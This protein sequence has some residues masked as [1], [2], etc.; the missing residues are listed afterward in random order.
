MT[1]REKE[2]KIRYKLD[3]VTPINQYEMKAYNIPFA[4]NTSSCREVYIKGERVLEFNVAGDMTFEQFSTKPIFRDELV[5]YLFSL[6][7]QLVSMVQN[8]LKLDKIVLDLRFLYVRLC[9][10]SLQ[11]LY[12]PLDKEFPDQNVRT[13]LQELLEKMMPA[14][15][16]SI[17]C[18]NQIMDYFNEHAEFDVFEFNRFIKA[19][20]EKSQLL[21]IKDE[22]QETELLERAL[23]G[24]SSYDIYQDDALKT[25]KLSG[26]MSDAKFTP[27]NILSGFMGSN[28]SRPKNYQNLPQLKRK[29]TGEVIYID[30]QVF[31]IGKAEQG[32][33]YRIMGN[34]SISRR[35]VYITT[36]KGKSYLRDNNSTN[37]TYLNG[38]QIYTDMD[39]A[40]PNNSIIRISNEEFVFSSN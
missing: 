15:T 28:K 18:A 39:V 2:Q 8:G 26:D 31:C 16:A 9:D 35:H 4:G 3:Q 7:K 6:S 17:E 14:Q 37:H 33:D 20:R 25:I 13:F 30:K 23:G 21:I 10:F 24:R 12:L 5:E 36:I 38:E 11:L 40:I 19:L 1:Q 34:K 29:S 32:V 22:N 27:N